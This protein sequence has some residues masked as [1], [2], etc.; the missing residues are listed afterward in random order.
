[1]LI[2]YSAGRFMIE[3]LRGD[4]ERGSIGPLSTSQFIAL[5]V[6]AAGVIMLVMIRNRN[7]HIR[8]EASV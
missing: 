7:K 2:L 1:Y 6:L 5:F 8:Q 4:A 3:F